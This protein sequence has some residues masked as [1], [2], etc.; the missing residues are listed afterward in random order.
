MNE[1]Q[2]CPICASEM[3]KY[4]RYP[5]LVCAEC[6]DRASD[7]KGRRL[8]FSN[9]DATGG[10]LAFYAE[11]DEEYNSHICYIDGVKCCADE[12]HF[13]GIAVEVVKK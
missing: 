11:T 3:Q 12:G 8:V 6:Y 13:G 10:Y 9:V 2:N 4:A 7:E 1:T 5:N